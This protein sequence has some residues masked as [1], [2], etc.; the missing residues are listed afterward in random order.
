[1][2]TTGER[3]WKRRTQSA[4]SLKDLLTWNRR[5]QFDEKPKAPTERNQEHGSNN[6]FDSNCS[7]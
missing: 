1:M 6:L 7:D 4:K 5:K 3:R 2:T